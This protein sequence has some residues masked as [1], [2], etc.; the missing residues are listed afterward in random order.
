MEASKTSLSSPSTI[1]EGEETRGA[2]WVIDSPILKNNV[3]ITGS[4]LNTM[5]EISV[6]EEREK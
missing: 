2:L 3:N 5:E 4:S 1:T 6:Y